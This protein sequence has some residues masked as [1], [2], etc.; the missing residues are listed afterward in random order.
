M[1][2]ISVPALQGQLRPYAEE[3]TAMLWSESDKGVGEE[4]NDSFRKYPAFGKRHTSQ[5]EQRSQSGVSTLATC[6]TDEIHGDS[7]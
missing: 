5:A 2:K 1:A 3:K 6:A 4:T 7:R